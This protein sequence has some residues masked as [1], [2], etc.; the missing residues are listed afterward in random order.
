MYPTQF[1]RNDTSR[2]LQIRNRRCSMSNNNGNVVIL[3]PT[4]LQSGI[5]RPLA[6]P[7][8]YITMTTPSNHIKIHYPN[9]FGTISPYQPFFSPPFSIYSASPW[10]RPFNLHSENTSHCPLAHPSVHS[11]RHIPLVCSWVYSCGRH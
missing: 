2:A 9:S 3:I 7:I 1:T 8:I 11:R 10:H 6:Q 5:G 4:A